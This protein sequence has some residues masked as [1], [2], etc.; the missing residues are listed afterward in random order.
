MQLL[1][2]LTVI[3]AGMC[4]TR[5]NIIQKFVIPELTFWQLLANRALIQ[6]I[7]IGTTCLIMH[8]RYRPGKT[9]N[10]N[11][12]AQVTNLIFVWFITVDFQD[13]DLIFRQS[14]NR[15]ISWSQ[16]STS[17]NN[18][19]RGSR[20]Y[21]FGIHVYCCKNSSSWECVSYYVLHPCIYLHNGPIHAWRKVMCE[22]YGQILETT[23]SP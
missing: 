3:M 5:S 23:P 7:V 1:G 8:Y 15:N 4:F 18:S 14:K 10:I 12:Q 19:S 2:I 13:N 11:T 21:A 22:C 16:W 6:T 20:R 17:T 9:L